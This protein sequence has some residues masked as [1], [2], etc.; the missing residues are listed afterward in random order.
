MSEREHNNSESYNNED[1]NIEEFNSKDTYN[2]IEDSNVDDPTIDNSEG[3]SDIENVDNE[4]NIDNPIDSTDQ[5]VEDEDTDT[6]TDEDADLEDDSEDLEDE[7]EGDSESTGEDVDPENKENLA[8]HELG[9]TV[10]YDGA[11]ETGFINWVKNHVAATSLISVALVATIVGGTFYGL[12]HNNVKELAED[13]VP[14]REGYENNSQN[15]IANDKIIEGGAKGTI[16]TVDHQQN[17]TRVSAPWIA[18]DAQGDSQAATL[19]PP[20]D[21]TKVGWY[22]RSAWFGQ[23]N[24]SSVMTSHINYAGKASYGSIFITLKK[25]DPIT[26]TDQKGNVYHYVVEADPFYLNKSNQEEYKKQTKDTINKMSGEN[27][28][29]LVTCGGAYVGGILG[30]EDNVIVS[31][32]LANNDKSGVK[33]GKDE[34]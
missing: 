7:S 11:V 10:E 23:D 3:N 1:N 22:G 33:A 34:K 13:V 5:F 20:E 27:K 26:I 25:G 31:A 8:P 9:D 19:A 32:K 18:I 2:D 12:N 30:Y 24:G 14:A 17:G 29:V 28:L 15:Y 6:E 4:N 21:L 16:T